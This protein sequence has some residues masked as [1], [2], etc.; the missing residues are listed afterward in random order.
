MK[1][2]IFLK[3]VL[4]VINDLGSGGAQKSLISFL[5]CLANTH[6]IKN[7]DIDLLVANKNGIFS[8]QIPKEINILTAE[9]N[10]VWMNCPISNLAT[11]QAFS[12]NSAVL[13]IKWMLVYRIAKKRKTF[14]SGKTLWN[15]WK[16]HIKANKTVYDIAISYMDGW[17]NYYVMEKVIANKKV[18]WIHNEY[19]KLGYDARYDYGYYKNCNMIIT[20]SNSCR[21]SF[22]DVFPEL[23]SKIHV[24]EN[25]SLA[26]EIYNKA[27]E[28]EPLEYRDNNRLK[29]VSIG[30][31]IEQNGFDIALMAAKELKTRN[32][33]FTWYIL[34]NG[35]DREKLVKLITLYGLEQQVKLVGIKNNPYPYIACADI[36]VQ[37]SRFEGKSIVLDEAK[38]LAKPI[39]VTNYTTVHDSIENMKSGIITEMNGISIADGI[40]KLLSNPDLVKR[41]IQ[42]LTDECRGNE[43]ELE[44]YI[45]YMF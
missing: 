19:K 24:L 42:A 36:F 33:L 21:D 7:Y 6:Y 31:L 38:I 12:I 17:P 13:K 16:N 32:I 5:K 41:M 22:I 23:A 37:T 25:I 1:G 26:G 4:I 9:K 28:F 11:K 8:D 43:K 40:C 2:D 45:K 27:K 20:I 30:R 3:K 44:K 39:V 15:L 14:S 18:L 35:P 34:G 10:M 29:I